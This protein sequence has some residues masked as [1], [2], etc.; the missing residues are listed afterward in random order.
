MALEKI[1][2]EKSTGIN[3]WEL[4]TTA[5]GQFGPQGYGQQDLCRRPLDIATY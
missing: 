5:P 2:D 1:F 4:K 3:L